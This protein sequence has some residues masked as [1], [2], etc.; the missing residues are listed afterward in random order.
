MIPNNVQRYLAQHQVAYQVL[1]HEPQGTSQETAQVAHVS[2]K[3]F[4][5]VVLLGTSAPPDGATHGFVL[6]VLPANEQVDLGCLRAALGK[7]VRLGTEDEL[8]RLFPGTEPGAA[9]PFGSLADVPVVAD[10]CLASRGSIV[11]HGGTH[12]DLIEMPWA[13]FARLTGAQIIDYGRPADWT[14]RATH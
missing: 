13:E 3:R 6:A 7:E 10:A 14:R 9:P 5:K 11:F 2:G 12:T 4:A 8:A 1:H